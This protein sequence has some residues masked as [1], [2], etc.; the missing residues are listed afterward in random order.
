MSS[1]QVSMPP[2]QSRTP[3]PTAD[4][5]YISTFRVQ[6]SYRHPSPSCRRARV[7]REFD[8]VR[9]RQRLLP[10]SV[11]AAMLG[12]A[13][14]SIPQCTPAGRQNR[15]ALREHEART[16]SFHFQVAGALAGWRWSSAFPTC[17]TMPSLTTAQRSTDSTHRRKAGNLHMAQTNPKVLT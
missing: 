16:L 8:L 11:T 13:L 17:M 15:R 1:W 14:Q 7:A 3:S 12:V 4:I 2:T 10:A 5:P 9:R 6:T